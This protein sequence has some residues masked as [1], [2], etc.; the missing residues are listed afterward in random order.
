MTT[1]SVIAL[2]NAIPSFLLRDASAEETATRHS[3]RV[4]VVV[5][6]EGG[7][8]G[9]NTVVP[10]GDDLY[11]QNRPTLALDAAGLLKIDEHLGLNPAMR[12]LRGCW[13]D[14]HMTILQNVGYPN[15][16]RSH[17][18][19]ASI[20]QSS[21]L[22][23]TSSTQGWLSRIVDWNQATD[24]DLSSAIQCS[25]GSLTQA[26]SGGRRHAATLDVL[27]RWQREAMRDPSIGNMDRVAQNLDM[28]YLNNKVADRIGAM[29]TS[30][31]ICSQQLNEVLRNRNA[32]TAEYPDTEFARQL[33]GVA[34]L[35]RW[36]SGPF[37]YYVRLGSFDTHSQQIGTHSELLNDFATGMAAF[38][39]DLGRSN[40]RERVLVMAYS[41]FGRRVRENFQSGTDHG[42]AGPVFLF[43]SQLRRRL[44]GDYSNLR[45]LDDG[46]IRYQIDF[47][48]V[49]GSILKQWLGIAPIDIMPGDFAPIDI[50]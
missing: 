42:A 12:S 5:E 50:C 18:T 45:D 11:Y 38:L 15:P 19:S 41:E 43:G 7:N 21:R 25:P 2:G 47:R 26:L 33:T 22:D 24:S 10:Y 46:D 4:F 29:M 37:I 39:S 40:D 6:L 35:I 28:Q 3:N 34:Q 31:F 32:S 48:S 36:S 23:A 49:Y 1:T 9:L 30:Q 17:F 14:G 8:D 13:D 16:N 20:W 44:H 27:D